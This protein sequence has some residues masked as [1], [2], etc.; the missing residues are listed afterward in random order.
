MTIEHISMHGA[1]LA[2]EETSK[3]IFDDDIRYDKMLGNLAVEFLSVKVRSVFE[4]QPV[5]ATIKLRCMVV[6][7]MHLCL[8]TSSVIFESSVDPLV[9]NVR[10]GG[11]ISLSR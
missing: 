6:A 10:E 11:G 1:A 2:A 4:L 8:V 7:F 9:N 5:F 3:I